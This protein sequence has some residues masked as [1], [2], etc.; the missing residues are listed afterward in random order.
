MTD[1][2]TLIHQLGTLAAFLRNQAGQAEPD[3]DRLDMAGQELA[4]LREL[5]GH[6]TLVTLPAADGT[7]PDHWYCERGRVEA[8]FGDEPAVWFRDEEINPDDAR[9]LGLALLA[10]ADRATCPCLPGAPQH[11][12]SQGGYRTEDVIS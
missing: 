7:D 4:L 5:L 11:L 10:A 8:T 1:I 2:P 9:E 3:R 6:Q 12:H